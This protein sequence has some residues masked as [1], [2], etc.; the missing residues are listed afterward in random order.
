MK[1][2]IVEKLREHLAGPVDTECK[3]VYLLCEVRK[4]LDNQPPDPVPFALRLYCHWAL[5]VDLSRPLTTMHF[6]SQVD[7]YVFDKLNVGDTN[8]TL[9]AEHALFQE[10]VYLETFRKELSQ[11]LAIHA[12]PTSLCDEDGRWFFFLAAYAGVIEDGSL[13]CESKDPNKLRIVERVTFTESTRKRTGGHLPFDVKWDI[14]LK[15]KRTVEIEVGTQSDHKLMHWGLR[16]LN[17]PS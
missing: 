10:F 17:A 2:A 8:E 13:A 5:H 9:L 12:L 15:D 4:L 6:L 16:L 3:V 7:S 14:Q 1:D 11:F